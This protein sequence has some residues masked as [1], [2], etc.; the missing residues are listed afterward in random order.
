MRAMTR[1]LLPLAAAFLVCSPASAGERRYAVTDF[2]RVIVEGPYSVR[3]TVGDVSRAAATG[4]PQALE[5]VSV[6]VQGTTLRVRRNRSAWGGYP[7][8]AA[9]PATITL[10]TRNLRGARLIG[11]GS[12]E[13]TGAKGLK[14]E[15]AIDGSG[16]IAAA[17]VDADN[18]ALTIRGAGTLEVAGK[19]KKLSADVQGSGSLD[20]GALTAETATLF[21]ATSGDVRLGARRAARVT[22]NGLGRVIIDGPAACTLSGSSAANVVCGRAR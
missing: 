1:F 19:A 11:T 6:D 15:L 16:R 5:G 3:L 20:G 14:V 4:S 10:T 8:R 7:G 9:E 13:L 2:D 12:L 18:L 21:A 17:G 22:S